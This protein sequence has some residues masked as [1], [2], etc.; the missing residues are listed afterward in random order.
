MIFSEPAMRGSVPEKHKA[1]LGPSG[2]LLAVFGR[3]SLSFGRHAFSPADSADRFSGDPDPF[4][5]DQFLGAV[6][7]VEVF[8]LVR[9]QSADPFLSKR[10][11]RIVG[12]PSSI[13][14][15]KSSGTVP[16]EN[17]LESLGMAVRHPQA[18]CGFSQAD[19]PIKDQ[20]EKI[21]TIQLLL[22]H[23][24]FVLSHNGDILAMQLEG[25]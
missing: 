14:V 16:G 18:P 20:L 7:V 23:N 13:A 6:G 22:T 2:A 10:I 11:Q 21:K 15:N 4:D 19:P 17:C 1:F 12:R 8:I 3:S 9:D 25:T 5:G 24:Y